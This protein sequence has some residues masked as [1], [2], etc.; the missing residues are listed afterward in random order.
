MPPHRY[1]GSPIQMLA[2]RAMHASSPAASVT[3]INADI[4]CPCGPADAVVDPIGG[5]MQ[6]LHQRRAAS[7][8]KDR[9]RANWRIAL[10][11]WLQRR[12]AFL[13][14]VAFFRLVD[15]A[16]VWVSLKTPTRNVQRASELVLSF[17][18]RRRFLGEALGALIYPCGASPT[19]RAPE[20]RSSAR[21]TV[22]EPRCFTK[23]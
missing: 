19:W 14:S 15:F 7:C 3:Q 8:Y 17:G 6:S 13:S 20:Q 5:E 11:L 22:L 18:G 9:H 23:I 2:S 1:C 12:S 16:P 10:R 4:I 21:A